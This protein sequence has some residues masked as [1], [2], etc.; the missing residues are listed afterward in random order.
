[1]SPSSRLCFWI[2][3]I[4]STRC[5][6]PDSAPP[7]VT[8]RRP[9]CLNGSRWRRT[10]LSLSGAP[11]P[12]TRCST[13]MR[14]SASWP[15]RSASSGSKTSTSAR[16]M[17]PHGTSSSGSRVPGVSRSDRGASNTAIKPQCGR[18]PSVTATRL[19]LWNCARPSPTTSRQATDSIS[20]LKSW[21]GTRRR[22]GS[23]T[24]RTRTSPRTPSLINWRPRSGACGT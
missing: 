21:N 6:T 11:I 16:S 18:S 12:S 23:F 5:S 8:G 14:S 1:M 4:L 7:S 15:T 2:G 9:L 17:R 19:W 24:L 13:R 20:A 10:R 22:S 3:P